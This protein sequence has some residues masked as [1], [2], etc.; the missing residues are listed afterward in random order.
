MRFWEIYLR[1]SVSE[2]RY[3]GRRFKKEVILFRIFEETNQVI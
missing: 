1:I 2:S 3:K